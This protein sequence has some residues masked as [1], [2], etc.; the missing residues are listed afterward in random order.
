[1]LTLVHPLTHALTH[2]HLLM[3]TSSHTLVHTLTHINVISH[4]LT[5]MLSHLSHVDTLTLYADTL[6]H[7]HVDT[8]SYIHLHTHTHVNTHSHTASLSLTHARTPSPTPCLPQAN[9]LSS[10]TTQGPVS[11][12]CPRPGTGHRAG[13]RQAGALLSGSLVKSTERPRSPRL[14]F[15]GYCRLLKVIVPE[16][17]VAATTGE[18]NQGLGQAGEPPPPGS[19]ELIPQDPQRTQEGPRVFQTSRGSKAAPVPSEPSQ[20][21]APNSPGKKHRTV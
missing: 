10:P 17:L 12:S 3:Q 11:G 16:Q 5:G 1:M 9:L 14:G 13:R 20:N 8:H 6:S 18:E 19:Y 4:T 2:I 7:S 15:L 21:R